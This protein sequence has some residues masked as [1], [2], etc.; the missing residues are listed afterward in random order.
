MNA[1][2][3]AETVGL[4]PSALAQSREPRAESLPHFLN[5]FR[6]TSGQNSAKASLVIRPS[7]PHTQR[8]T[9]SLVFASLSA[10]HVFDKKLFP[11]FPMYRAYAGRH[12]PDRSGAR[13]VVF[14]TYFTRCP[15][16]CSGE[17]KYRGSSPQIDPNPASIRFP[18]DTPVNRIPLRLP[19]PS[20]CVPYSDGTSRNVPH[21]EL[22]GPTMNSRDGLTVELTNQRMRSDAVA[23]RYSVTGSV[24]MIANARSNGLESGVFA[25][26]PKAGETSRQK[27][28]TH[29][30]QTPRIAMRSG[31]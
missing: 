27:S 22:I 2:E 16:P 8:T 3:I 12:L 23:G 7:T 29:F 31:E 11:T 1:G 30:M 13:N 28:T 6:F 4:R 26:C 21:A 24:C 15:K 25:F 20:Q 14:T 17:R 9:A 18:V 5:T 19:K 10:R